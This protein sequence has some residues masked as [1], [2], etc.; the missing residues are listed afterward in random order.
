ML[1][2]YQTLNQPLSIYFHSNDLD[3]LQ[4]GILGTEMHKL[5]NQVAIA[6]IEENNKALDKAKK[7]LVEFHLP[8]ST[9]RDDVLIRAKVSAIRQGSIELDIGVVMAQVFSIPGATSIVGNLMATA[10]WAIGEYATKVVGCRVTKRETRTDV[11]AVAKTSARRRLGPI[12]ERAF[13]ELQASSNGGEFRMKSGDEE[14]E[15]KFYSKD[16]Q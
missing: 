5:L 6:L 8:Q 16:S 15:I 14:I 4:V 9:Y 3:L 10:I 11:S 13:K 12:V 7:P 2:K 1:L